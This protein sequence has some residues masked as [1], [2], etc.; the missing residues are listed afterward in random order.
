VTLR[1]PDYAPAPLSPSPAPAVAH[2]LYDYTA[3]NPDELSV[4]EGDNVII[5]DG[6]ASAISPWC[7]KR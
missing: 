1:S 6:A 5:L 4:R 2:V 7:R 3:T